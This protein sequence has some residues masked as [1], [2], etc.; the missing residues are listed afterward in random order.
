MDLYQCC[1]SFLISFL[2]VSHVCVS[3]FSVL[4]ATEVDFTVSQKIN[5]HGGSFEKCI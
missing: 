1:L 4:P 3:S 2:F 5:H